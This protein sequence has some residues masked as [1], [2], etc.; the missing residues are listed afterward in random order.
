MVNPFDMWWY[1]SVPNFSLFE[2]CKVEKWSRRSSFGVD[3]HDRHTGFLNFEG[4]YAM[5]NLLFMFS[6]FMDTS[7]HK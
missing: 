1:T 2:E 5:R 3:G 6:I 7:W 4:E